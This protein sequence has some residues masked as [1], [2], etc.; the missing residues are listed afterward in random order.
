MLLSD[1]LYRPG[2]DLLRNELHDVLEDTETTFN[3]IADRFGNY[4]V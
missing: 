2:L 1:D 3:E 4:I